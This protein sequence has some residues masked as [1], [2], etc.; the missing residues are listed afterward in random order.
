MN[1]NKMILVASMALSA[2]TI[3]A[4]AAPH[5]NTITSAPPTNRTYSTNSTRYSHGNWNRHDRFGGHYNPYGCYFGGGYG[6]PY[7]GY[8]NPYYGSGLGLSIG[9]GYQ[10]Y[11]YGYYGSGYGY[12]PYGGGYYTAGRS[13][14]YQQVTGGSVVARVQQRLARS[15]YYRGAIDGVAGYGTRNAIRAFERDH[16]LRVDGRI[17]GRLLA[18][19]GVA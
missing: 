7:Y 6:Y 5:G 10:P 4:T 18:T 16:S 13:Y 12:Q 14:G 9:F 3:S 8:G 17:D 1:W 2:L 15:G 19:L 11:G